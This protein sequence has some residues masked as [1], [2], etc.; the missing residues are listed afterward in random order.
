M[1]PRIQDCTAVSTIAST[2]LGIFCKNR[3]DKKQQY[4][5]LPTSLL[6]KLSLATNT[7]CMHTARC[8]MMR[9]AHNSIHNKHCTL[10]TAL[11]PLFG[12][13]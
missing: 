1:L 11:L 12:C 3:D 6:H 10:N 8:S 9:N 7:Q 2:C 5:K 13:F 4:A